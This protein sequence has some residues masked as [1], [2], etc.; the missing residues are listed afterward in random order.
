[1]SAEPT[2]EPTGEPAT[3][4]GAMLG[5]WNAHVRRARISDPKKKLAALVVGSYANSDG[6]S[7]KCGVSRLAADCEMGYSTARRYLAWLRSVGLIELIRAGNRKAK[8][9]D[10]YRLTLAPAAF[11]LLDVPTEED[12]AV[13]VEGLNASNRAGEKERR[14]R[15]VMVS[16][17]ATDSD[18]PAEPP[19]ALTPRPSAGPAICAH[20]ES[21]L[22][23]PMGEPLPPMNT[24]QVKAPPTG[25]APPPDPRRPASATP[26]RTNS[27]TS[28][29]EQLTPAQD[30]ASDPLPHAYAVAPVL[31]I[32]PGVSQEAPFWV[33]PSSPRRIAAVEAARAAVAAAQAAA[34]KEAK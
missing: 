7:V 10:E 4:V 18:G 1:V 34:R 22:R 26:P 20:S 24:S 33:K 12:Y 17:E 31:E 9:S 11:K 23:S 25:G 8:R 32:R 21:F 14:L 2:A 6:T 5:T 30:Q 15:S 27:Q 16:A 19:S 29:A 3:D 13:Y 28:L